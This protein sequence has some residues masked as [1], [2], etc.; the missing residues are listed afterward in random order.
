[1]GLDQFVQFILK[2]LLLIISVIA[3]IV[4]TNKGLKYSIF[5]GYCYCHM[6][7]RGLS[8]SPDVTKPNTDAIEAGK[9]KAVVPGPSEYCGTVTSCHDGRDSRPNV[10]HLL[11]SWREDI[12]SIFRRDPD[13][14]GQPDTAL[15]QFY[16]L[17]D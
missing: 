11:S 3:T 16:R 9:G 15:K 14:H 7:A 13:H 4:Y 8:S 1:M 5:F 12:Q 10:C 17:Q 6:T 2:Y